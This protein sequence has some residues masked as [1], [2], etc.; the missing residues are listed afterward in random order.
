MLP[1]C[2]VGGN[3]TLYW[4][5]GHSGFVGN[6][7]ADKL[8]K[9]ATRLES[10]EPPQRDGLLWYLITQA[11]KR[12]EIITGPLLSGKSNTGKFIKKIDAVL[13]FGKAVGLYQ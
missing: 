10:E 1:P 2:T 8:A 6:E 11:L 12:A 9:A 13:Y 7:K 5:S 4:I 3:V